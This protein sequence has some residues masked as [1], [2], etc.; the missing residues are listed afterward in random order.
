MQL[1]LEGQPLHTRS[2]LIELSNAPDGLRVCGQVL[3]LRKASFVPMVEELQTAGLIHDMSLDLRVDPSTRTIRK[4]QVAQRRVAVEPS[5]Q[6]GGQ[7][8]RDVQPRLQEL[9][10]HALDDGFPAVLQEVFGGPRG[11]S[12]I[13]TLLHLMASSLPPAL[14]FEAA[15]GSRRPAELIFRRSVFV[16]GHEPAEGRL[17]L[18]VQLMDFHSAPL[19]SVEDRL[20]ILARQ[21]EARV[22]ADVDLAD[23]AV[24]DLAAIERDRSAATLGQAAWRN[25]AEK[26][27]GLVGRPVMPGFGKEAR[28][29][30][31]ADPANRLLADALAQVAPGFVQCTPA[32]TDRMIQQIVRN[33]GEGGGAMGDSVLPE[34]MTRGGGKNACYMW[35]EDS[36]LLTARPIPRD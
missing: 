11:C 12:H 28:R 32:L 6:T 5:A 26:V 29:Q 34:F 9:V 31:G 14:D 17:H 8:C 16:D 36:P 23:L 13:L 7:S 25:E 30:L 10:G 33:R 21:H 18:A 1:P 22:L 3:D 15:Q 20:G 4:L 24:L 2:L 35:R 19:D 27:S